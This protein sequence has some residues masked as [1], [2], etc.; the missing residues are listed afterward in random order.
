MVVIK[1]LTEAVEPS[2]PAL[3]DHIEARIVEA[4]RALGRLEML[5]ARGDLRPVAR[6]ALAQR[7]EDL[8]DDLARLNAH[9]A[10][11]HRGQT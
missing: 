7:G 2:A 4:E 3:I 11:L 1:P 10:A 6:D 9:R 8:A 5:L